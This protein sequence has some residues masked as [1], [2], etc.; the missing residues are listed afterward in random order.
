MFNLMVEFNLSSLYLYKFYYI[1]Q[2]LILE[3]LNFSNNNI[4]IHNWMI[5]EK[6]YINYIKSESKSRLLAIN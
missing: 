4:I 6:S 3:K 2:L 1:I 5:I